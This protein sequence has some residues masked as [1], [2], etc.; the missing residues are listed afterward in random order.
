[1]TSSPDETPTTYLTD[2]ARF[3]YL[4]E[5]VRA[6]GRSSWLRQI[7]QSWNVSDLG[8]SRPIFVRPVACPF[9]TDPHVVHQALTL[10]QPHLAQQV[11]LD[12]ALGE[13]ETIV[14]ATAVYV[15]RPGSEGA[16]LKLDG[17][18]SFVELVSVTIDG[19]SDSEKSLTEKLDY[20]LTPNAEDTHMTIANVPATKFSVT[21]VTKFDPFKNLEL[22]GLYKSSG[23]F[24]TQCEAEGFR[25]ITY[26]PDR[27]V[28]ISHLP[29]SDD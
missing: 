21:V 16:P 3:P 29:H 4:V 6:W 13:D 1:M 14:T 12:F 9:P 7:A 5:K 25:L 20:A 19:G 18:Q 8:I 24:C 22:S 27:P 28:R 11:S 26:F 17:R 10:H 15:P 23:T 2:Y